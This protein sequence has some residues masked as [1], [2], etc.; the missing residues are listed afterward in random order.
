MNQ[1][2][3]VIVTNND[4]VTR[5]GLNRAE[6]KNAIT[7]EMYGLLAAGIGQAEADPTVRAMLIY[8]TA[9]CFTAGNDL[10]DFMGSPPAEADSPVAQFLQAISTAKKPLVA[11]VTGPAIGIGTTMLLHCDMVFAGSDATL[12]LPFVNLGLC[13]EAGSSYLLPQLIGHQ[14]AAELLLLGKPFTAETACA[15]GLVNRVLPD[16][17]VLDAAVECCRELAALPPSALRETKR[18]MKQFA[19]PTVAKTMQAEMEA[20]SQRLTSPEAREAMTAFF[21]RRPPDF[22][23][24]E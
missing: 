3:P 1:Q 18:L 20:F 11:A 9:D 6:K 7:V 5:L 23:S 12:Q 2:P 24:F 15:Y 4:G 10:K 13:S 21:E 22:S 8:G 19:T 16:D 17:E 14:R